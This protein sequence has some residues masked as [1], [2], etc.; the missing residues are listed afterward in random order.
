MF[1]ATTISSIRY[2]ILRNPL[3]NEDLLAGTACLNYP[4][5]TD[6]AIYNTGTQSVAMVASYIYQKIGTCGFC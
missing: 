4:Y 1:K 2:E 5:A 3:C 6:K